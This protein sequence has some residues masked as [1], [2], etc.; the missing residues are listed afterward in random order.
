[1]PTLSAWCGLPEP[2]IAG[3][4]AAEAFDAVTLDMQHGAVDFREAACAI[5]LVAARGKPTLVRVPV[6]GYAT[7]ARL[8]DAG[9]AGIIAPMIGSV[10]DARAFVAQTKYPPSG[11]RSWGPSAALALTGLDTPTYFGEA[12][13][14]TV[15][16]AMIETRA[17]LEAIDDILA[18][19]GLDGIF[20]GP[21]DLSVALSD[22]AGVTPASPAVDAALDHALARTRAA[23]KHIGVYAHDASRAAVFRAKGFDL[24]AACSDTAFLAAGARALVAA[25]EA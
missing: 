5:P 22:G 21:A 12:N 15:A 25:L 19:E 14:Q 1:M 2:T 10:A 18:V 13:A 4:L 9:A 24:V 23:G 11:A 8:L 20:I 7:A 3:L 16:L 6:G 17:A